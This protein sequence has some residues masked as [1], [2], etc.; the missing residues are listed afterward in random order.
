MTASVS[1][2]DS[3][4]GRPKTP[5]KRAAGRTV[6]LPTLRRRSIYVVAGGVWVTGGLWLI[7]HYFMRVKDEFGF[8]TVH[9]LEKWWLIFHAAFGF[10]AVWMFGNLWLN[11]I[12][13]GWNVKARWISG[14]SLFL[15]VA[16]LI[17]TGFLLYYLGDKGPRAV[18]SLLH[19]IPGLAALALFLLHLSFSWLRPRERHA[20]RGS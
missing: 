16:W 8:D 5:R 6:P 18:T 3:A 15:M 20:R 4:A 17:G 2:G 13:L 14:G 12:K 19:W 11:H 9:P 7:Y 1:K 10:W